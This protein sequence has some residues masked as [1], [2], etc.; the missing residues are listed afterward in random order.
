MCWCCAAAVQD[1]SDEI[2]IDHCHHYS[3]LYLLK[4]KSFWFLSP[5]VSGN[6]KTIISFWSLWSLFHGLCVGIAILDTVSLSHPSLF[7]SGPVKK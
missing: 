1:I 4:K 6:V 5:L 2:L 3:L 7:F